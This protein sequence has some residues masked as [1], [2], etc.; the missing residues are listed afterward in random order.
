MQK[1]AFNVILR[2]HTGFVSPFAFLLLVSQMCHYT[3]NPSG[4]R[5][6]YAGDFFPWV[7]GQK[8]GYREIDSYS[9][10]VSRGEDRLQL[11]NVLFTQHTALPENIIFVYKTV[12]WKN[13]R[14][15]GGKGKPC[16]AHEL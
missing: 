4:A 1:H 9:R 10:C 2:G 3:H 5:T 13:G 7:A 8:C 12:Y 15:M 16:R 6:L 14:E 11:G